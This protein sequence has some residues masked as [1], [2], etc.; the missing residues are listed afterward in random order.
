[1]SNQ[2]LDPKNIAGDKYKELNKKL[3]QAKLL[4]GRSSQ[5][6]G[7][8]FVYSFAA[9]KNHVLEDII[10]PASKEGEEP[11]RMKTAAT[12]GKE[13]KW[14]PEFL[15][16]LTVTETKYVLAHETYHIVMQH[17][18]PK[19]VNG[20]DPMI[21]NLAVD[22]IVNNTI[23]HDL[24]HLNNND[25][26]NS[27]QADLAYKDPDNNKHPIWNGN[28]GKP[29]TLEALI[30]SIEETFQKYRDDKANGK[31]DG[32]EHVTNAP[33]ED[34]EGDPVVY[35]DYSL[36]GMSAE[37]IYDKIMDK[38]NEEKKKSGLP[39]KG[40]MDELI[41]KIAGGQSL[42]EHEKNELSKSG[43]LEEVMKAAEAARALN[44]GVMPAG[45]EDM[46]KELEAP[47]LTWQD[48]VKHAIQTKRQENGM[49]NDWT[50]YKRRE[51]SYGMYRPKKKDD[52]VTW[53]CLLD[54]SGSM[55]DE[56]IAYGVSQLK[57]LDG[58]SNGYV[59]PVDAQ[60]YWNKMTAINTMADLPSINVVG[61]GGTVFDD[62]F[63]DYQKY[64]PEEVDLIVAITDG[65]VHLQCKRP[66]TDVVWVITNENK[67]D[68]PFGRVA[69][70]RGC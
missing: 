22:Y 33:T 43:L 9:V 3:S 29:F 60:V 25:S 26:F 47:K 67:P 21:W 52:K 50:R 64:I 38:I 68:L 48:L 40:E 56:D 39:T 23:E 17:C 18:N 6:A 31:N 1:M 36:H 8:P 69:P 44:N 35:A 7:M 41:S 45:I 58:R 61:R 2:L 62:F 12:N 30:A 65:F 37:E 10:I 28:F 5:N 70:L 49:K 53:L 13:Y 4:L 27:Y 11:V 63:N 16:K 66:S 19:R 24:R 20:R 54:T 51:F 32:G 46:L 34:A 59:V 57:A 14:S 42:D 15:E 55:S